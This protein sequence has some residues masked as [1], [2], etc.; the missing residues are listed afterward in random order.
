M[1]KKKLFGIM[2]LIAAV[3][4]VFT[5]MGCDTD[6][7]GGG[8]GHVSETAGRITID[9]LSAYEGKYVFAGGELGSD[10]LTAAADVNT[11]SGGKAGKINGGSVTLKVWKIDGNEDLINF[12]GSGSATFTVMII[13]QEQMTEQ[14]MM[15]PLAF[16][17]CAVTFSNGVGSGTFGGGII[18][19]TKVVRPVPNPLPGSVTSGTTI[20]LSS[21]TGGAT[22]RYTIDGSTPSSTSTVY[23][24]PITITGPTTIKAI[25]YKDGMT[26][27]EILT[28]AYTISSG[29]TPVTLQSVTANGS[30]SVTTTELTLTFSQAIQLTSGDVQLSGV[31]GASPG[32]I[33]ITGSTCKVQISGFTEGGT[34]T[35]TVAK[36]GYDISGSPKTVTIYFGGFGSSGSH[37]STC[38]AELGAGLSGQPSNTFAAPYDITLNVSDLGG[39]YYDEG[40]LNRVIRTMMGTY[41]VNLD[42]SGSTFTSLGSNDLSGITELVSLSM[43][44][45]FTD[46]DSMYFSNCDNLTIINFPA[47]V[48]N[49]EAW[50]F[51]G[52]RRLTTINIDT[53]NTAYSSENGVLYNKDKTTLIRCP[54]GKAG[55]FT[56][57]NSVTSIGESAFSDCAGITGVTIPNSVTDIENYAFAECSNLETVNIP[58]GLTRIGTAVFRSCEKLS[59]AIE[60]PAGVSS[61]GDGAFEGCYSLTAINVAAAN[62]AYCSEDGVLYNKAKTQLLTYPASSATAVFTIASGVSSILEKAFYKCENLTEV[63]IPSSVNSIARDAFAFCTSLVKVTFG[64]GSIN[65]YNFNASAFGDVGYAQYGYI[66]DLRAKYTASGTGGAGTYTRDAGE[67]VWTKS[68]GSSENPNPGPGPSGEKPTTKLTESATYDQAISTL[69]AI[70]AYTGTPAYTKTQAESI[71][72][73]ISGVISMLGSGYW[74]SIRDDYV[75]LINTMID[76]IP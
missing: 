19:P 58:T 42:L 76:S 5:F 62:A 21:S 3:M 35:V 55:V 54:E 17:E 11:S 40:S 30:A 61:I 72:G 32:G 64:G 66:G 45:T 9:G 15:N 69:D 20:T 73:V 33:S 25:A 16:D 46:I 65:G 49:I 31:P 63:T 10:D 37:P 43:P 53:A 75:E 2:T 47:G 44:A 28:A 29:G 67:I 48:N 60:I 4:L 24:G 50:A 68:G 74:G 1:L 38:I 70:I 56:V 12:N 13:N 36:S 14:V 7:G 34:L 27:S 26:A 6:G 18:D 8:G 22:I 41:F 39:D 52:C 51:N 23:S 57:P 59:G 71:K